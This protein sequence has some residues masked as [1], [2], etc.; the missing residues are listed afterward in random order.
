MQ[1]NLVFE[2]KISKRL[3]ISVF[4]QLKSCG[5]LGIIVANKQLNL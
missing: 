5:Y 3:S 2:I 4:H 1:R